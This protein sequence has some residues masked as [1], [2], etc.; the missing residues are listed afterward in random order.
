[1]QEKLNDNLTL[2]GVYTFTI[3]DAKTGEIKR[4]YKYKNIIPTSGRSAIINRLCNVSPTYTLLANYVALGSGTN[5]PANTD[6]TLQT[7]V[8]RNLVASRDEDNNIG[9]ITGFFSATET[10]GTYREAGLFI[11]G[12]AS[13][14]TGLLFS[15]VA[16]N[17][18]KSATESL[19][20][21]YSIEIT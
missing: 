18:T 20:L 7:E 13:A 9:Y 15:R 10:D 6:T 1:M 17:I 8:Y 19:T 12:T 14:D 3:R 4:T 21:D 16:I 2:K 5:T 11:D